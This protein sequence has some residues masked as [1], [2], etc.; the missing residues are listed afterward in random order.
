ME[1]LKRIQDKLQLLLRQHQALQK[2]H[3]QLQ[4]Q[5]HA[6]AAS[7]KQQQEAI[8]SLSRQVLVLKA[9]AGQMSEADKKA[10]DKKINQYLK[11]I[12]K[13]IHYLSQ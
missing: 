6:A 8:E 9:A 10:L 5:L 11:Q 7:T 2:S 4:E 13:C 3:A 12:D 1:Q